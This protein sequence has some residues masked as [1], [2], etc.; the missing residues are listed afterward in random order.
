M[1]RLRIQITNK[2]IN[3]LFQLAGKPE[4]SYSDEMNQ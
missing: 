1:H 4:N 3:Q 2:E